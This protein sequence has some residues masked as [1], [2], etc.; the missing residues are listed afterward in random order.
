MNNNMSADTIC[1]PWI[2]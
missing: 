2:I 1:T